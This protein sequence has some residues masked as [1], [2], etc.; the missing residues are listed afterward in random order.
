VTL[1]T[2]DLCDALDAVQAC[3]TQFRGFGRVRSFAGPI[4]TVRCSDDIAEMRQIVN[5]PGN[6]C[7]LVVDGGGSLRRAIFGDNMAALMIKNGWAGVV[8]NGAVRDTA[9]I[10]AMDIGVKALG[11]VAKRGERS[12]GGSVDVP[13]TFGGVTFV[14]DCWVIADDDGVVVLP[15]GMTPDAIDVASGILTYS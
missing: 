4:R 10:D 7:V 11:T 13:V 6:G 14:P 2:S 12:G 15:A 8:V 5:Q 3:T 9:E 1:K